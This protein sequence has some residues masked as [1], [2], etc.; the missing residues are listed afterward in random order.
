MEK[1]N[2]N[3]RVE[4]ERYHRKERLHVT[5]TSPI[6]QASD[7]IFFA[8]RCVRGAFLQLGGATDGH[9]RCLLAPDVRGWTVGQQ[10]RRPRGG[11]SCE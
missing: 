6:E 4:I 10:L 8:A 2:A 1:T 9:S 5:F 3:K 11:Q 7:P